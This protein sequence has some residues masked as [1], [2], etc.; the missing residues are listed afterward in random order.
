MVRMGRSVWLESQDLAFTDVLMLRTDAE[1][2]PAELISAGY[3]QHERGQWHLQA[4]V[5]QALD[6]AQPAQVV[7]DLSLSS[8]LSP[9]LFAAV[10]TR[11]RLL[12][13]Q[14]LLEMRR[15]L[16]ASERNAMAYERALW[17]RL[18]YPLNVLAM[19]IIGAVLLLH[20]PTERGGTGLAVFAGVVL[21]L[22]YFILVRLVEGLG[23]VSALPMWLLSLMPALTLV[24]ILLAL[25]TLSGAWRRH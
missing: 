15:F 18:F 5:R 2:R 17:G 12:S 23:V 13:T 10:V 20:L 7:A 24:V 1:G 6:S 4:V 14:D 25:T 3:A 21:G 22:G 19:V 8:Q 9:E 16:A 11:P